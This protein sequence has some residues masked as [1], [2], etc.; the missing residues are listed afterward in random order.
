MGHHSTSDDSFAY[1][2]RHEV[3]EKKKLDNPLGR[4]KA[5]L[6]GRGWWSD[7]EE[8]EAKTRCK[9]EVLSAFKRA[10]K[11]QRPP[12]GE[13]FEGV[14]APGSETWMIVSDFSFSRR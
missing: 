10:E 4:M 3:E 13:M 6:E 7:S 12:V 2:P 9:E 5:F 1:R 11:M 8:E 14:Y